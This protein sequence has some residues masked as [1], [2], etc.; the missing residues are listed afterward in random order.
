MPVLQGPAGLEPPPPPQRSAIF[1]VMLRKHLFV[2]KKRKRILTT[3]YPAVLYSVVEVI[4]FYATQGIDDAAARGTILA[5]LCPLYLC[6]ALT[7]AMQNVIVEIVSEKESKMKVVQEIYGLTSFMYWAS[8]TGYFAVVSAVAIVAICILLMFVAPLVGQANPLLF[9]LIFA[10]A[11]IQHFELGAIAAVFFDKVSSATSVA[12]V[13]GLITAAIAASM[14]GFLRGKTRAVWYA[15]SVLPTVAF[16]NGFAATVWLENNYVCDEAGHCSQGLSFKNLWATELCPVA[17]SPCQD[18]MAIFSAGEAIVMLL[19]DCALYGVLA[20]WLDNVWQGEFGAAKPLTFCLDPAFMCPRRS[21]AG[22]REL[23][24]PLVDGS[25]RSV[26]MSIRG[27]RKVF[28]RKVA[29]DDVSLDFYGGEIFALLGHNGAGKTT[30]IN[31]VVGLIPP[32][33]GSATVNGF[34]IRTDVEGVRRQL[35]VCPQDNP[36]Y[37]VFTVRQHLTFFASLRGVS[38]AHVSER[39]VEVL[40]ALGIPEKIDDLCV[41]LSGGQ[42][43]RLWVASA[44][45]GETP[46]VFLDEPT[47]G[48]DPSSRRELWSLLLQMRA[49]GRAIIFTTHYLEE[50]DVLADR[51]AVL[52]KGRV[53]AVGTSRDLKLQFGLGYHL[54]VELLPA[55]SEQRVSELRGLVLRHV[56]SARDEQVAAEERQ[57]VSDATRLVKFV[58][59]YEEARNFGPLLLAL[60]AQRE[61]IQMKDYSLAMTSLE[62][63]FMALGQQAESQ[64]APGA[65]E[66]ADFR[67]LAPEPE[68]DGGRSEASETRSIQAVMRMRL[69]QLL[70]NRKSI[71]NT[72][73]LPAFIIVMAFSFK[74][75][76]GYN[77]AVYPPLAFGVSTIAFTLHLIQDKQL[78]CRYVATAQGLSV[79]A[80]WAGTFVAHYLTLL[81]VTLVLAGSIVWRPPTGMSDAALPI[82]FIMAFVFPVN[83]L[84]YSYNFSLL[85][86]TAEVAMKVIPL[87]NMFLGM[88]PTVAVMG[89]LLVPGDNFASIARGLHLVMSLINPMYGISGMLVFFIHTPSTGILSTFT[90][91]A[92]LPLYAAFVSLPLW[93]LNLLRQDKKC[94]TDVPGRVQD[95]GGEGKDEDVLAEE[96]RVLQNPGQDEAVRYLNLSHTYR[97]KVNKRWVETP[98]VRGISLGVRSGECFGLLGPNGAGKTTTL[99]VL[100]GEVRPP[101][102]GRLIV[103]GHDIMNPDGLLN[104]YR[105]LGVC[106]QVDP[107]FTNLTGRQHLMFYGRVKGVPEAA[108]VNIV[109]DLFY[110]L[111]FDAPDLDKQAT[112][113][114]G[115]MKRKLS[116]GMALIG[117][118]DLLFLDE[119]S[120]AVDAGAKRHLWKVIKK[121]RISQT[122]VLTTHSMEE[123][124][125]LCDRIAIQ[126]KGQLRCLGSPLHIKHKYGS[127]Y[128]L[129]LFS[130]ATAG[131]SRMPVGVDD[132]IVRFVHSRLT[133]EA[134]LLEHHAGRY[135]FQLPPMGPGCALTLGHV[136]SEVQQSMEAVGIQDYSI[137]QPSLEQVFIR[138]AREQDADPVEEPPP[139]ESAGSATAARA[140]RGPETETEARRPFLAS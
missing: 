5:L 94:R 129:E 81:P 30:A 111:G 72:V 39:I 109:S 100:T 34:D 130:Q 90:C 31:C 104:A 83:M 112:Q 63:V 24:E 76:S 37:D 59:P 68:D 50:A 35:S 55:A 105:V 45:V 1:K 32:T 40:T 52:A 116:L 85:F 11:Y 75:S 33:S 9:M 44:L 57:Q 99:A 22:A 54:Q 20:W 21:R 108:L 97:T 26:A 93:A 29:V 61:E 71:Y 70:G 73:I 78:K 16:Y 98:A 2:A 66:N 79:Q 60:D 123:A 42:K 106:P 28:G 6:F 133:P 87:C 80:Y 117:H 96:A 139:P 64:A 89:L 4:I 121:R 74:T 124:E 49:S 84:L 46:V 128:Q 25:G 110:R 62:E 58:L 122:V 18:S 43:R 131:Q 103:C 134:S 102:S 138:F 12:N 107:L 15:A 56:A 115:G 3:V 47:S 67:E 7:A 132:A 23:G 101:S 136:F 114:S 17:K 137:T 86:S 8:W 119:P 140:R 92:A 13:I 127:G 113:Y 88:L 118:S 36:L 125:A 82:V 41:S 51:K 48:M 135:L 95:V 77:I 27:L 65:A 91:F 19:I 120:A 10:A 14:Q 126:V 69:E 38:E 53:Q